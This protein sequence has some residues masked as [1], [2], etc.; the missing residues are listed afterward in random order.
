LKKKEKAV[1]WRGSS[2][3]ER[4]NKEEKEEIKSKQSR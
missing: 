3:E 2:K 1:K 4:E